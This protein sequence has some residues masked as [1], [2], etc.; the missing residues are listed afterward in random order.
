MELLADLQRELQHG[1]DPDHARPRRGRRRRRQDRGHVRRAGSS[2][3]RRCTSIYARP[4][5]PYTEGL[6]DSIPSID[7][8]GETLVRDQGAAAQP[9]RKIPPGCAF[10]PRCPYAQDICRHGRPP[11]ST[12][13]P[14]AM[15]AP[16]TSGRR[17]A[18]APT[19]EVVLE[20]NDL[21]KYFPLTQGIV[22]KKKIG[23]VKAVDGVSFDLRKGETLGIVGESGC[24]KSTLGRLLMALETPTAGR[25]HVPRARTSSRS[26]A[27]RSQAMRRN[28]QIVMQDPYTSLNPRM[29]V[30][31]IVGEPFE[32]HPEVAPKGDRAQD[33]PGAARGGRAEP[34]A[35]QPLPAPVLRRPAAAHRH[36][37]RRSRSSPRSSSAT[38][39]SRRWT[40]RSRRR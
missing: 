33:G 26:R 21:V 31:D 40:S 34:R 38:S 6:L 16:A 39:R 14:R 1:A 32:I 12:S 5:H 30:G 3:G 37:P 17:S 7:S 19:D 10:N 29:T 9:A 24:G 15:P 2:S 11:T 20:V 4:A 28:I 8:K 18:M 27:S 35:H 23:D 25:G 13:W 22:F 36:R